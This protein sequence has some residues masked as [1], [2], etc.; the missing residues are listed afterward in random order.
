[1]VRPLA[2]ALDLSAY[3]IVPVA[4]APARAPYNLDA[5]WARV[6]VELDEARLVQLD[7]LRVGRQ[8]LSLHELADSVRPCRPLDHR[9]HHALLCSE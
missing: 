8:R 6:A 9:G 7:R 4:M 5:L 1:M 3:A 2:S